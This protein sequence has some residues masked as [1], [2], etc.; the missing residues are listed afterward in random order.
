MIL[1]LWCIGTRQSHTILF[2][3]CRIKIITS[4]CNNNEQQSTNS[5]K[6]SAN[7]QQGTFG[8]DL[9]FLQQHD[10]NIV[11]LKTDNDNAEI[12]VSP[13]YQAKVFTSTANGNE[14]LSFGWVNYIA[15]S[16]PP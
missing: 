14:G 10:D 5:T 8:Y 4:A 16:A 7:F 2:L 9:H 13:K 11:V 12:I 3:L 6:D 15:C 1:H